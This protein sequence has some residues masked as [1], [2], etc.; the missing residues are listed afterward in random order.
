VLD[1]PSYRQAAARLGRSIQQ[2]VAG[3][4]LLDELELHLDT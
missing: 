1:D 2:D 3:S 4:A